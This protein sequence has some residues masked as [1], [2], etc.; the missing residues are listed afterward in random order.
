LRSRRRPTSVD[1]VNESMRV[2]GSL[3]IVPTT[4]PGSVV[5]ITLSTPGG[6]PAS[7]R[8]DATAKAVSGVAV[9]GLRIAVHPAARA[10]AIL[11]VAIAAG[12]FHGVMSTLTP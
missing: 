6:S 2:R 12:K 10:G 5:V 1:P 3:S 9:A 4:G 8:R 7:R 11:R